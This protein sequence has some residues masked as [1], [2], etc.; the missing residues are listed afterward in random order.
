MSKR[1]PFSGCTHF[2]RARYLQPNTKLRTNEIALDPAGKQVAQLSSPYPLNLAFHLIVLE[3]L[4]PQE[5][6]QKK[7]KRSRVGVTAAHV[8]R[9]LRRMRQLL[10]W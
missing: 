5:N 3:R 4:L 1:E 2:D 9:S 10:P 6:R 7:A 8:P